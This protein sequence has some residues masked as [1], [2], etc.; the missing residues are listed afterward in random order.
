MPALRFRITPEQI[1]TTTVFACTL[2]TLSWSAIASAESADDAVTLDA[3][4]A[5]S[6]ASEREP[7]S[8]FAE[9]YSPVDTK[10]VSKS[11]CE[12]AE[13]CT[14]CHD[15][16]KG[17]CVPTVIGLCYWGVGC[18]NGKSCAVDLALCTA[19][20]TADKPCKTDGD[21]GKCG[22][23]EDG[24]CFG[25][26]P[27]QCLSD[28]GCGTGMVCNKTSMFMCDW[29]C[30]PAPPLPDVSADP[31]TDAPEAEGFSE[32]EALET[33]GDL[34]SADGD[35]SAQSLPAEVD[36]GATD[37]QDADMEPRG[38]ADTDVWQPS[39]LDAAAGRALP[40]TPNSRGVDGSL[41]G[42]A[43]SAS[44]ALKPATVAT[45]RPADSACAAGRFGSP[46]GAV[47]TWLG[48]LALALARRGGLGRMCATDLRIAAVDR[49]RAVVRA[50]REWQGEGHSGGDAP[51]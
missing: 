17:T 14:E 42:D 6:D 10:D 25:F 29:H 45:A 51:T 44:D 32:T 48:L 40:D 41:L 2:G 27:G 35:S 1:R 9:S 49:A 34:A 21:C 23:C 37:S 31:D 43:G 4:V 36:V 8:A 30:A 20:C 12:T 46:F 11:Q 3:A 22:K 33:A 13:E 16:Q 50:G 5:T 18:S 7:D 24:A 38:R 26:K 47:A 39:A 15:C 19:T 28:F